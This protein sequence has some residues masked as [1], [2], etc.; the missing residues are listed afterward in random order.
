[1]VWFGRHRSKLWADVTAAV[2]LKA[3]SHIP[4]SFH[5][6]PMPFHAALIHTCHAA[7]LPFSAVS[8]VKV[9]V[10]DGNIRTVSLLLVT[11]FVEFRVVA[12]RSRMRI[13]RPHF[14]SGRPMLIQTY[15]TVPMLFS[16]HAVPKPWEVAFGTALTWHGR[17]TAWER[18]GMCESNTAALYKSNG[19]DTI[20][21]LNGTAWQGNGMICVN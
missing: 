14:V 11:T 3:N 6:V 13:R 12:G 16:R 5:P 7:T 17:G 19:K 4:C 9:R 2:N 10:V 20:Y 1:M 8:F 18:H 21:T 15:H